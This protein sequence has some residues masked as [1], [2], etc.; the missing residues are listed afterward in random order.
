MSEVVLVT[1][2]MDADAK[3]GF[4][5]I[6]S[7]GDLNMPGLSQNGERGAFG[8]ALQAVFKIAAGETRGLEVERAILE[9]EHKFA[10]GTQWAKTVKQGWRNDGPS[11]HEVQTGLNY[12]AVADAPGME[13]LVPVGGH[14]ARGSNLFLPQS[15]PAEYYAKFQVNLRHGPRTRI[16][17]MIQ[18]EVRI[19][20][21]SEEAL[22]VGAVTLVRRQTPYV[23]PDFSRSLEE[24]RASIHDL[25]YR[26]QRLADMSPSFKF[27]RK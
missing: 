18:Y 7:T 20:V 3:T 6:T 13:N 5:R 27:K 19:S 9:S 17:A 2:I 14:Q 8:Y 26:T 23:E 12:I 25:L 24:A 16:L 11:P 21:A 1:S 10:T 15:Y 4:T 22:A